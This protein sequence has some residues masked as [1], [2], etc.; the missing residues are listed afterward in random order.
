MATP[1][2]V[3]G[4]GMGLIVAPLNDTI[5]SEVPR[6]DAGSASGLINTTGQTGNALGLALTSVVFFG[7]MDDDM[8]FGPPYVEAF[9]GALWWV[10]AVLVA[11]FAVMFFLPRRALPMD[12]R[13]GAAEHAGAVTEKVPAH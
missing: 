8:I 4:V 3:M 7:Q 10:V 12:E 6:R 13:E 9:R 2:V 1:L 5:L 11:I